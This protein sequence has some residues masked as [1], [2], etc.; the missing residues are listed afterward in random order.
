MGKRNLRIPPPRVMGAAKFAAHK[1][2]PA[3]AQSLHRATALYAAGDWAQAEALC[4]AALKSK[5]EP[6]EALTLLGVIT[7]QTNRAEE[8]AKYFGRVVQRQPDDATYHNNFANVL[9]DLG[10][11]ADA[12]SHYERAVGLNPDYAEAHYNRG[13]ALHELQRYEEALASYER[14][15]LL[16]PDYVKAYNN[17]GSSL[18]FLGRFDAALES[19][20]RAL[21]LKPDHIGALN[22]R[23]KVLRTLGRLDESTDS[24][25]RVLKLD[26]NNAEAYHGIG[27]ALQLKNELDQALEYYQRALAINPKYADVYYACGDCLRQLGRAEEA[28][29]AYARALECNWDLAWLLGSWLSAKTQLCAWEGLEEALAD[30]EQRI[31]RYNAVVTP[32]YALTLLDSPLRQLQAARVWVGRNCPPSLELP[33]IRPYAR[34]PRIRIGYYSADYYK[35]AT[36]VLAAQMFEMHDRNQF[37]IVAFQFGNPP[38]DSMTERLEKT[39]DRF[40][41]VSGRSDLEIARLSRELEIDIAVDL[42]GYTLHQRAGIFSHR[43]APLQVNYLGY[44]GTTGAVF[45]DYIVADPVLIPEHSREFYVEKVAY[46]PHSYQVNDRDRPV[47]EGC[48]SREE[49]GL[50][51]NGFV[52]CCFNN[53]YKIMPPTFDSWMKVLRRVD[54]SVLWLLDGGDAVR[55]N[56][57]A[58]A[59]RRGVDPDRL[60]FAARAQ[61][62]EHLARHRA[63]DLFVDTLPCN[64]HTTASDALWAGLPV[65]TCIGESL[66][67]RVAASLLIAVGLSELVATNAGRY[68]DLMVELAGNPA[69]MADFKRRLAEQKWTAPLFDVARYTRNIESIYRAMYERSQAGQQPDHIIVSEPSG[70]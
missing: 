32:F 22:N 40:I 64:A 15:L 27:L 46:L 10:R 44:P 70:T 65:L 6:I 59:Q 17:R 47:A 66:A 54:G 41:D 45:M 39:F 42:K 37:E 24:Y 3:P 34:R 16:K 43:A 8:A 57:R 5:V 31:D 25:Q 30:L 56:L 21:A 23:G 61:L 35:H 49:L 55:R 19:Y 20:D 26:P 62:P 63:A 12:L 52:F 29:E 18:R 53:V 11:F 67:A 1:S 33:P 9:R 38:R 50:P 58:E 51:T 7:A 36:A 60:V 13:A 2:S 48:P 28:T 4:R 68:E 14:A 69:L